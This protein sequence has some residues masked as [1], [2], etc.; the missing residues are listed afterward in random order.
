MKSKVFKSKKGFEISFMNLKTKERWSW[1]T[2]SVCVL[3][4]NPVAVSEPM[5]Y[6][7]FGFFTDKKK[8]LKGKK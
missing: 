2:N 1:L 5:T 8:K 3:I 6:I 4:E 7:E